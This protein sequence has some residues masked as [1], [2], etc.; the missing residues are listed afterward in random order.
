MVMAFLSWA[1]LLA[2]CEKW[3]G[4][5]TPKES[6]D[7]PV[8]ITTGTPVAITDIQEISFQESGSMIPLVSYTTMTRENEGEAVR[9]GFADTADLTGDEA[10]GERIGVT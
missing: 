2:G 7:N 9:L 3:P 8:E 5:G 6:Q 4:H 1:A 10:L